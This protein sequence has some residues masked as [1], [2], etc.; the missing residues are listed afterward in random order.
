ISRIDL[1]TDNS[2]YM[3]LFEIYRFIDLR[4]FLK[5]IHKGNTTALEDSFREMTEFVGPSK[6]SHYT[7]GKVLMS[8]LYNL[9]DILFI[10]DNG[11]VQ[12]PFRY[13]ADKIEDSRKEWWFISELFIEPLKDKI[14]YDYYYYNDLQ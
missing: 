7:V 8:S 3:R 14:T 5:L 12:R 13:T 9:Y 6:D 11:A 4:A 1:F 10:D 2:S